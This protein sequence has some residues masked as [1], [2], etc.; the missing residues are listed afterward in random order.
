M[1][2][3][4]LAFQFLTIIPV[5]DTGESPEQDVG[6]ATVYF[7]V[8]GLIE[9]SLLSVLAWLFLKVFPGELTSGLVLFAM[10]LINGGLHLDG[11]SDTFDAVA[12]RGNIDKKLAI[13]K[14]STI[15]PAG[16]IAIV[17]VLLLKYLLLN[18]MFFYSSI[19][20]YYTG[21]LLMPVISR[22]TMVWAIFHGRPAR[23]D[24]LGRMFI[25][26]TGLREL[27]TA[28]V[29]TLIA[30]F[31][32]LGV[33]S[34]FE[35]LLFH[36][37]FVLPVLYFFSV[38]AVWFFNKHFGGMTGDSF[39]SVYEIAILLFLTTRILWVQKFI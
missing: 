29:L 35:L 2:K 9:G 31:V 12:S 14:D 5:K 17:L 8:V 1:K 26:Y 38:S 27:I 13:M 34:E 10:V 33:I 3:M 18:S 11:L 24:G 39:G 4:L 32:T 28:T 25:E 20:V 21:L 7:P 16:V 19:S 22:C 23:Q 30:C 37:M 15:G 36:L 6:S